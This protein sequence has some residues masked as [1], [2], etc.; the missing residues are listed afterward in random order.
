M[1]YFYNIKIKSVKPKRGIENY[2]AKYKEILPNQDNPV[3]TP[4]RHWQLRGLPLSPGGPL[5]TPSSAWPPGGFSMLCSFWCWKLVVSP[6]LA[7]RCENPLT[8]TDCSIAGNCFTKRPSHLKFHHPFYLL[9]SANSL[10]HVRTSKIIAILFLNVTFTDQG[11]QSLTANET[12]F[13]KPHFWS[14]QRLQ[15]ENS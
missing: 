6:T 13:F 3:T 14:W 9:W 2:K 8:N 5:R 4:G 7:H 11:L 15:T 10:K 1:I 12:Q